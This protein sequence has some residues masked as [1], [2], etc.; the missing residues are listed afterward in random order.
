M[1]LFI[2]ATVACL[3]LAALPRSESFGPLPAAASLSWTASRSPTVSNYRLPPRHR[4]PVVFARARD[5]AVADA[6]A[7]ADAEA[8][9][10]TRR[11]VAASMFLLLPSPA[12]AAATRA[13]FRCRVSPYRAS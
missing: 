4:L 8:A 2:F 13:L 12:A 10:T 9:R 7:E 5:A 11:L 6:D 1:R 3:A